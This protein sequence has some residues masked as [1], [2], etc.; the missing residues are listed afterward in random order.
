ME[1]MTWTPDLSVGVKVLD[2]DHKKLIG[3]IN[4]LHFGIMAGHKREILGA[5]LD[6]LV[7]YARLHFA[8][9]E[10]LLA[11]SDYP[12]LVAHKLEHQKFMAQIANVRERYITAPARS[13]DMELMILL[14]DWLVTHIEGTDKQYGPI[15]NAH[16]FI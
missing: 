15:M 4:Q 12:D 2:D 3:I 10:S 11:R 8:R 14:S 7:D 6:Q 1:F 5:V 16:G 13:L 9:E